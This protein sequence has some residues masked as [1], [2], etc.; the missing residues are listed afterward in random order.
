[1]IG[2]GLTCILGL[3][4]GDR[5]TGHVPLS[6]VEVGH[7]TGSHSL[8]EAFTYFLVSWWSRSRS[9]KRSR[10]RSR[11]SVLQVKPVEEDRRPSA[12][13]MDVI[14]MGAQEH[15]LPQVLSSS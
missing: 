5:N 11:S 7:D 12:V 6:Q 10:S 15:G 3:I 13:Y 1:M 8:V 4:C 9:K 2:I 14:I